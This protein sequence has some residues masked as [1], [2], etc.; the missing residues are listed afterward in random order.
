M[1]TITPRSRDDISE[2]I[3]TL[4]N[5]AC[6]MKATICSTWG[7]SVR[8]WNWSMLAIINLI[9][10]IGCIQP[11][12]GQQI[13]EESTLDTECDKIVSVGSSVVC[14]PSII[15]M[16]ECSEMSDVMALTGVKVTD[17]S[18]ILG[19]YLRQEQV[20]NLESALKIG[21][22]DYIK[23]Y[24]MN[25]ILYKDVPVDG[26]NVMADAFEKTAF[27]RD[28]ADIALGLEKIFEGVQFGQ[29]VAMERY[30]PHKQVTTIVCL[31]PIQGD[32]G[33]DRYG[34][35]SISFCSVKNRLIWVVHYLE[36][37]GIE[38]VSK[39]KAKSDYYTLRLIQANE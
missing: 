25:A 29:P 12:P 7:Q 4:A 19:V 5:N 6:V 9:F 26:L 2:F 28:W 33:F 8:L 14:L 31:S 37:S 3:S 38:S 13:A 27:K 20:D 24:V 15:G 35:M 10:I 1:V 34:L 30:S 17:K 11:T 23:V 39:A 22:D 18:T 32:L 16:Q 21:L 36:Y